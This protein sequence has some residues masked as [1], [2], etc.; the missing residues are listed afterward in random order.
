MI[1]LSF[2]IEEFDMPK[3]Y[4][5]NIDFERQIAISREGL[6]I[7]LDLLK[8]YNAKATFFSTIIFAREC[9]DLIKR[10]LEEGHE[11]AS[12]TYYHS[13]F[14]NAH[15]KASKLYLEQHFSTEVKGLRMPRMAEVDTMEVKN[16]GYT[17]NSSVNPTILPGRYNKLHISK[18]FFNEKG[19]WQ[20]PTAVSWLRIPLFWLSFHNFPLWLYHFLLK[21]TLKDTGYAALYFHPWE[22]TDLHVKEFNFPGYVMRNSGKKM[23]KRFEKFLKYINKKGWQTALYK[24]LVA[25]HS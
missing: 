9:D 15:L 20:I 1:Y 18:H 17:Y 7:I 16:A 25:N 19:L 21:Q 2:D 14:E 22:F 5:Y 8:A 3:E 6:T 12:H 13:E 23:T 24:D 11:L 4:G 10:L